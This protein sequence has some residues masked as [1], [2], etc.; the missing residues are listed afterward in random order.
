MDTARS[1]LLKNVDHRLYINPVVWH[2][3]W[4]VLVISLGQRDR[5]SELNIVL[6]VV[7]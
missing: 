7:V 1:N 5:R 3:V 2:R 4:L 6:K